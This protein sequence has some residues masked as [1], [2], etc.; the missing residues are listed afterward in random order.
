M[1]EVFGFSFGPGSFIV[2]CILLG[3]AAGW[4]TRKSL[5]PIVVVQK[6]CIHAIQKADLDEYLQTEKGKEML[7][8]ILAGNVQ[9]KGPDKVEL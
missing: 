1:I 4:L 6:H 9:A 8:A 3:V 2:L 5:T 7:E